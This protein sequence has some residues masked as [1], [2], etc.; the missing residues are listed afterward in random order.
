MRVIYY[1]A[2]HGRNSRKTPKIDIGTELKEM[3]K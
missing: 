1:N 2:H 3:G